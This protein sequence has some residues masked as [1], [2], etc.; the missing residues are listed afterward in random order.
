M[1]ILVVD[2]KLIIIKLKR[3]N[4]Q[5][6]TLSL[7]IKLINNVLNVLIVIFKFNYII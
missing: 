5:I 6:I 1:N 7:F 3:R 2:L 4:N